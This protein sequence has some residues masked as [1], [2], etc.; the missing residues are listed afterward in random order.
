MNAGT[1]YVYDVEIRKNL[2]ETPYILTLVTGNIAVTDQ[3]TGA[4]EI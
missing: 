1:G 3:V 2:E 4:G